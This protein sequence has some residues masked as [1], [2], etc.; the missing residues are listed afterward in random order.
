[1]KLHGNSF[2]TVNT[3]NAVNTVMTVSARC[4]LVKNGV[5]CVLGG[6]FDTV[7]TVTYG[8]GFA[9]KKKLIEVIEITRVFVRYG[10]YGQC[11]HYGV[12][13]L[14]DDRIGALHY[15]LKLLRYSFDTVTVTDFPPT[16]A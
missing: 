12:T 4:I 1:M 9:L 6:I 3:V 10:Q 16:G 13:V 8:H 7:I 2:D 15:L 11:G 14:T 5:L